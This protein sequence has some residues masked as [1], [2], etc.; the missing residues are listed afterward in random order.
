MAILSLYPLPAIAYTHDGS[1][2]LISEG[3]V[4]Y[5]YEEEKLSRFQHAVSEFPEKAAVVGFQQTGIHPNQIE[6]LVVT[7]IEN[8]PARPDFASRVQ[9][10]KELL[11][12]HKDIDVT[13][14]PHHMAHSALAVLTSPFDE[15][16]FLTMDGGGDYLMGHWGI[17]RDGAFQV[18]EEFRFSP[19]LIFAYLTT[20]GGF[21]IFEEG[22]LMGLSAFGKIDPSLLGWLQEHFWIR[23]G[24]AAVAISRELR[25]RWQSSLH[26][27]AIDAGSLR[28][29]KY[30]RGGVDF[31]GPSVIDW[32][33][34]V[35]PADLA[36]TGQHFFELLVLRAVKNIR[37][38]TG[39]EQFAL[40]G[41]AF[42]NVLVN[43]SC[44]ERQKFHRTFLWR[45]TMLGSPLARPCSNCTSQLPGVLN[46]KRARISVRSSIEAT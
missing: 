29:P 28:R 18:V 8:C 21:S 34:R 14:V 6:S 37:D 36:A 39:I 3:N 15:C 7:S 25:L 27:D 13:C 12:L 41:G 11:H 22:K 33:S 5:S 46:L 30:S 10:A 4:L 20:L 17:F 45:H 16:V 40:G 24:T 44:D 9:F 35:C 32:P 1:A 23:D 26:L 38:R 42:L 43:E 2:T 31:T 19:A